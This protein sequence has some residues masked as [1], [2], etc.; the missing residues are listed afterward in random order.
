MLVKR[1]VKSEVKVPEKKAP[2]KVT[3]KDLDKLKRMFQANCEN[4][5]NKFR[6]WRF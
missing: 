3:K 2:I 5:W 1:L 4:W 6:I